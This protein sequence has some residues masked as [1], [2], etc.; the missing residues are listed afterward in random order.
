MSVVW[1]IVVLWLMLLMHKKFFLYWL[2]LLKILWC[3]CLLLL[4]SAT[5]ASLCFW[6]FVLYMLRYI[7][8]SERKVSYDCK[9]HW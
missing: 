9:N 4:S 6:R 2:M 5:M 8:T 7:L 3:L 1:P